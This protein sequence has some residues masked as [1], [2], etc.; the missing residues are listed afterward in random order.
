MFTLTTSI[1]ACLDSHEVDPKLLVPF[2][3]FIIA[4]LFLVVTVPLTGGHM[5]PVFTFIAALKGVV[6]L[7][8]ALIYVLA[9]CI[10]SIVGFFILKCVM[11][12]RLAYAY[13]LGGCA[14]KSSIGANYGIKSQDALLVEFACTF[15]V[16]FVG[17][18]LAFDKKRAR[19]LGLPMVCLV[20]AGAMSL[21][22]F[23]SVSVTGRV[24]YAGVGLN[25]ARCLGPALLHGGFLWEG[26]WVFWVGPFLACVVYYV[27][28]VNLPKEGLVWVDGE[29]DVLNLVLSN[30]SS[31]SV[32][33][34]DI[35]QEHNAIHE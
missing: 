20:V 34:R 28:S 14:I 23:V 8:R 29:Y 25:P 11:D 27:V 4:F 19:D 26:H 6:T 35:P 7:T 22:V 17:V 5:S 16:L 24:G 3:V 30:A 12:P 21:A 2:A 9:Q 1:I 31:V 15:V 18:T 32:F 33:N 10:G 13:S